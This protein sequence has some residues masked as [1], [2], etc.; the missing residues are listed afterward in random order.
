MNLSITTTTANFVFVYFFTIILRRNYYCW[1]QQQCEADDPAN[2][3]FS[4]SPTITLDRVRRCR[5]NSPWACHG[6]TTRSEYRCFRHM[7]KEP[8]KKLY[9]SELNVP[10]RSNTKNFAL[11]IAGQQNSNGQ[12]SG[13]TG[14]RSS[15]KDKF[16]RKTA[17]FSPYQLA[18][19]SLANTILSSG[20]F[21]ADDTFVGLV[22]DAQ[23]NYEF[24]DKNT[25]EKSYIEY[26]LSKLNTEN[27]ETIYIAGHSRGGCL[28]MRIAQELTHRAKEYSSNLYQARIIIQ[29]WDPV[30]SDDRF[31]FGKEFGVDDNPIVDNP[32]VADSSWY[33]HTTDM[34]AQFQNKRR[35]CLV[36]RAFLSGEEFINVGE[37]FYTVHGFGH[38]GHSDKE[39]SIFDTGADFPWY[40]QSFHTEEHSSINSFHWSTARSHLRNAMRMDCPCGK[41]KQQKETIV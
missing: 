40:T 38:R 12:S 34:E 19:N 39:N 30:C 3:P 35:S 41:P 7:R 32:V 2:N 13:I 33:V 14:Q 24:P 27:I 25:I 15:Y 6:V 5:N 22:F 23:F 11:F 26:I 29:T 31:P 37:G 36:I 1:A 18:K 16:E 4:L 21:S 9:I 28:A 8:Q 10:S 17:S 20:L